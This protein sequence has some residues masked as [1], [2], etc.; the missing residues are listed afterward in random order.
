[1]MSVHVNVVSVGGGS[2]LGNCMPTDSLIYNTLQQN[3]NIRN[4]ENRNL[5]AVWNTVVVSVV[6][7]WVVVSVVEMWVEVSMSYMMTLITH[8]K[9]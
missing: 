9:F 3:H 5:R 8:K 6:E 2:T 7:V 4:F 1:M